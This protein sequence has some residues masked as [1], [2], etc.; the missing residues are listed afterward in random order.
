MV[1]SP[2]TMIPGRPICFGE[3]V[4]EGGSAS[5]SPEGLAVALGLVRVIAMGPM[6][7]IVGVSRSDAS[8]VWSPVSSPSAGHR[9]APP[10]HEVGHVLVD[11][12]LAGTACGSR[13]SPVT[14]HA[15][16]SGHG[17]RRAPRRRDERLTPGC[18]R[19]VEDDVLLTVDA[20][21]HQFLAGRPRSSAGPSTLEH[22]DDRET[23][24]GAILAGEM[25][26]VGV[27]GGLGVSD[28]A[29]RPST[30]NSPSSL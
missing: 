8:S 12:R 23:P 2:W 15:G 26:G 21:H 29:P 10:A 13:P 6:S 16:T 30:A 27:V 17:C 5:E 7:A 22:R 11:H 25:L 19:A 18:D 28:G 20:A 1:Q 9:A 24:G 4:V 3:V 14:E